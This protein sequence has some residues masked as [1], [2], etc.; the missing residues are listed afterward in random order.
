MQ[1]VMWGKGRRGGTQVSRAVRDPRACGPYPL[2]PYLRLAHHLHHYL[3]YF[4]SFLG[5]L[6][7]QA[8]APSPGKHVYTSEWRLRT[9]NLSV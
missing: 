3:A 7:T 9:G 1:V 5:V 4:C 8:T 2:P 6:G